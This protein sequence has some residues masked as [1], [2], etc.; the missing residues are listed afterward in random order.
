MKESTLKR[1]LRFPRDGHV[2]SVAMTESQP[3]PDPVLKQSSYRSKR[4]MSRVSA[5]LVA[6]EIFLSAQET[7][8]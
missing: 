5:C 3:N 4:A 7:K 8:Y 2:T 6:I 1:D